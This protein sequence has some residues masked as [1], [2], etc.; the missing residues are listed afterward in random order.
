MTFDKHVKHIELVFVIDFL[1]GGLQ[2]R[3]RKVVDTI[4]IAGA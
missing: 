4:Q 3:Q 2:L 1:N